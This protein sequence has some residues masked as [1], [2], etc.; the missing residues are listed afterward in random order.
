MSFSFYKTKIGEQVILQRGFDITKKDQVEG[1]IPVVS[2]GGISSYHNEAKIS[3]PGVVLGRKGS[4]GTV[5]YIDGPYWPHDTTLWVK[6]FKN[7][8]PIFVYYF[9][10]NISQL[11]KDMDVGAAN[12]AL[13]RNHVH[14]LEV[15]WADRKIQDHIAGILASLDAKINNNT[16][17]NQTL[18][19]IAQA[20]FKSWFVDFEPV[21]AKITALEVGGSQEEATLAA[22]A[23]IS[24]KRTDALVIFE[25][26]HPE[27]YAELKAT[28][29]LFPSAMQSSEM[30]A[31]PAG[32]RTDIVDSIVN[33][34]KVKNTFPPDCIKQFGKHPVLEQGA[35]VY[36]GY[37]DEEP[38]FNASL[39]SPMFIF[40]DHTCVMHLSIVPFDISKNTLVLEGKGFN[41]YWTFFALKGKQKFQEYK[42]HWSDLK[43]KQVIIPDGANGLLL[44]NF[45]ASKC[46]SLFGLLE[47]N[48]KQ[49]MILQN[50][51]DTLLP[52]L[53]SGEITLP[54]VEQ[55]VS[56]VENV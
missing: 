18:E 3:G 10:K 56:E 22:M 7:N 40:G 6:D 48:R 25:R 53:L 20:L 9:F 46:E 55:A 1:N 38:S 30:G 4:L 36:Q 16:K 23:T 35:K 17:I 50:I 51:R 2:S 13:N 34:L 21:K 42:R 49:N 43:V 15:F 52:K 12:P 19:Q 47:Q 37:H 14:P 26:E 29:E 32:W 39:Q 27:Q 28:A 31:I 5:F 11:L 45:F 44:T 33:R 8:N 54:E 24:G 41:T